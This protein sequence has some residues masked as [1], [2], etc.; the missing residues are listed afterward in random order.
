MGG[1]VWQLNEALISGSSR[2]L[3]GGSFD[4]YSLILLSSYRN[5]FAPADENDVLVGFRVASIV[6]IP[7]PSSLVLAT[8]GFAL[9]A[10]GWRRKR[11]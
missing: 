10:W 2:G 11:A 8:L 4:D 7:E 5:Y 1:N 9:A 3:R 6:P